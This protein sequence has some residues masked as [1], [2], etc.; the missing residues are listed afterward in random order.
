[1]AYLI[2]ATVVTVNVLEGHFLIASLFKC[3]ISYLWHVT[4]SLCI[5]RASCPM[6]RYPSCQTTYSVKSLKE[7]K[8]LTPTSKNHPIISYFLVTLVQF[9]RC[10]LSASYLI[11]LLLVTFTHIHSP[12]TRTCDTKSTQRHV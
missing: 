11:T 9:F 1:M 4:R 3:D 8:V 5:C 12:G 7:L 2:A 6:S 10:V